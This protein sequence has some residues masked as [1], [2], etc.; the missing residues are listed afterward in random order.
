M[1]VVFKEP[2]IEVTMQYGDFTGDYSRRW[3]QV[4]IIVTIVD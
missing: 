4:M 3:Q 2:R 1:S